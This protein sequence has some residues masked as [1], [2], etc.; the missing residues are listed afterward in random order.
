MGNSEKCSLTHNNK[1]V[2]QQLK[3]F[4]V[5]SIEFKDNYFKEKINIAMSLPISGYIHL[6][7]DLTLNR[8]LL[9]IHT[10]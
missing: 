6:T 5:L 9:L 7:H 4:N 1:Q 8:N 3:L 10:F 2:F